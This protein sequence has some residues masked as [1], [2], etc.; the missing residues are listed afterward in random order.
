L[1]GAA[2]SG[3]A[4]QT[5]MPPQLRKKPDPYFEGII[6]AG[7]E[8]RATPKLDWPKLDYDNAYGHNRELRFLMCMLKATQLTIAF[9][10][11]H[12]RKLKTK[13][14]TRERKVAHYM[15]LYYHRKMDIGFKEQNPLTTKQ[16]RGIQ[17]AKEQLKAAQ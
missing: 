14:G 13:K 4:Q 9:V 6:A 11:W 12:Q 7:K 2:F 17:W 8:R 3:P 10:K 5:A 16:K 1:G 15:E